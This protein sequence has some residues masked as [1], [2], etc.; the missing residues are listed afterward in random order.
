MEL[1]SRGGHRWHGQR[2]TVVKASSG[3]SGG[4]G[5]EG[6][7]KKKGMVKKTKPAGG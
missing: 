5:G 3:R 4:E 2:E 6:P 7:Q 1:G